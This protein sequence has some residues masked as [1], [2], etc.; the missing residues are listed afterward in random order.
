M[1]EMSRA[2]FLK[3][4]LAGAMFLPGAAAF[5]DA[6]DKLR[7][8]R[9]GWSR[10]KTTSPAWNR[11][12][13]GDPKL[14]RFFRDQTTLNVDPVWYA[15]DVENLEEM[16]KYPFLFSQ[17]VHVVNDAPGR[18]NAAEYIRRGGFLM[19]DACCNPTYTPDF[20]VFLQQHRGFFAAVLPESCF[21]LLPRTHEVYRC[22]FQIP[23]GH[24]PH[25]F[26]SNVYDA[27]KAAHGLYGVMIGQ[28]MAAMVSVSG[29]QCGW[30]SPTP[31]PGHDAVCMRMMVNI[32]IYAMMQGA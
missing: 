13:N 31:P 8:D 11:H 17:G 9:V 27:K 6:M 7:G 23:N 21:V 15:A 28:R 32:Y 12:S 24:P 1:K 16:T 4:L 14:T 3:T 20:D 18:A 22:Y 30:E 10:L 5:G 2:R 29:L 19:V 26:M 25:T